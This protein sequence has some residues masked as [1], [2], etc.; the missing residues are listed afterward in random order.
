MILIRWKCHRNKSWFP[1]WSGLV[2]FELGDG[3][4]GFTPT[5][6]KTHTRCCL[7]CIHCLVT[8]RVAQNPLAPWLAKVKR[9]DQDVVVLARSRGDGG[10]DWRITREVGS[11]AGGDVTMHGQHRHVCYDPVTRHNLAYDD[12]VVGK[13]L[14]PV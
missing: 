7:L 8:S 4:P 2:C 10:G 11:I 13:G 3:A 6:C 1:K 5:A 9:R 12:V 14:N